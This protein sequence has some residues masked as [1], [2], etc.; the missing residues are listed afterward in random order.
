[1][2]DLLVAWAFLRLGACHFQKFLYFGI[3]LNAFC[4]KYND[5]TEFFSIMFFISL[6]LFFKFV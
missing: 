5:N 2:E 4:F 6:N 1:M 3:S